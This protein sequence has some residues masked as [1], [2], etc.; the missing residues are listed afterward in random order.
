MIKKI[1]LA[2]CTLVGS[3]LAYSNQKPPLTGKF[4]YADLKPAEY[5]GLHYVPMELGGNGN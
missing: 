4:F 3:V 2:I 5:Y 1:N